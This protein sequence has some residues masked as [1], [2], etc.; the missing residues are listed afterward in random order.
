MATQHC[1]QGVTQDPTRLHLALLKSDSPFQRTLTENNGCAIP[2]KRNQD[3]EWGSHEING[4]SAVRGKDVKVQ[5]SSERLSHQEL[6]VR[7]PQASIRLRRKT[8][9]RIVLYQGAPNLLV[10][11]ARLRRTRG[12][13][14]ELERRVAK[15]SESVPC[16]T[17]PQRRR[18]SLHVFLFQLRTSLR[19]RSSYTANVQTEGLTIY[20]YIYIYISSLCAVER[21]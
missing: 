13:E 8:P 5:L 14:G 18:G 2:A 21:C 4:Q 3:C 7:T 19:T 10:V 12:L 6:K 17:T 9:S 20:K 11:P 16:S 15:K 1:S